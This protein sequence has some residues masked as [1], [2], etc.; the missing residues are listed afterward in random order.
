MPAYEFLNEH[1]KWIPYT[2]AVNA[3]VAAAVARGDSEAKCSHGKFS[4]TLDLGTMKQKNDS[5]DCLL[6]T[7]PS[8]R[9]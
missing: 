6:Y 2:D 1:G 7:S 4:Y 3:T 9:D 5:T 8:P